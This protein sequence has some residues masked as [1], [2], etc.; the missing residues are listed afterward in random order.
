[1]AKR[2]RVSTSDIELQVAGELKKAFKAEIL[3]PFDLQFRSSQLPFCARQHVIHNRY[4]KDERPVRGESYNFHFYV[5]IGSAVHEVVQRF[6]GI[7]KILYGH[8]ICCG[9][10]EYN[11]EGSENCSVCGSP[12]KYEELAPSG[13]EL[14]MHVDGVSIL[15]NGVTEFKTTS[16]AKV[17]T[18]TNPY[19]QHMLQASCYLHALN[20]EHG[21]GLDKLIFVYFSRD[22]PKDFRVFVRKPLPE[23]AYLDTLSS[24]QSAKLA[25]V[26]GVIPDAICASPYDGNWRG[27]PYT[28]ICFSPNLS[29]MLLPIESLTK[30]EK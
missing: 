17:K 22:N 27:C 18:L 5:K 1:M 29:E 13:S 6:L 23:S 2:A 15:Y 25:V 11:R 16:G 14:G 28:G 20:I 7:A 24:Y 26:S 8:W 3:T 4:P 12:Q 30:R 9:V 19:P 10:T 21:W